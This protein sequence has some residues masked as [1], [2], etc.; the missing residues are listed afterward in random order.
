[1]LTSAAVILLWGGLLDSV[2]PAAPLRTTAM[3]GRPYLVD[4]AARTGKY[5]SPY[6]AGMTPIGNRSV[7]AEVRTRGPAR[8]GMTFC[9]DRRSAFRPVGFWYRDGKLSITGVRGEI[10]AS[11]PVDFTVPPD[12]LCVLSVMMFQKGM[13]FR[14]AGGGHSQELAMPDRMRFQPGLPGLSLDSGRVLRWEVHPVGPLQPRLGVIGD[15]FTGGLA[16]SSVADDY[17]WQV[18]RRLGQAFELNLGS[19]GAT[20]GD[21]RRR[22]SVELAPFRPRAVWIESGTND[23]TQGFTPSQ[24]IGNLWGE[25]SQV[26]WTSD[27]LLST[28]PPRNRY[29]EKADSA[30]NAVNAWIRGSGFRFIDRDALVRSPWDANLLAPE[31]DNGDGTHIN[32][33]GHRLVA[34]RALVALSMPARVLPRSIVPPIGGFDLLGRA[35]GESP[36]LRRYFPRRS[37]TWS[38]GAI[39]HR[40]R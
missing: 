5:Q 2:G 4:A 30:R 37:G 7:W 20:T 34:D 40:I 21:D 14:I 26:T 19:G 28:I 22:L 18:T 25:I 10:L 16:D 8:V 33:E 29:P 15:S 3:L 35:L 36:A 38:T 32:A 39:A 6:P 11:R 24:I 12:S 1:M 17:V 31:V 13:F 9:Y 23:I 27:I